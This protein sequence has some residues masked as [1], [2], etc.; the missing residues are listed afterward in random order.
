MKAVVPTQL[1]RT[2]YAPARVPRI[3]QAGISL[4]ET[5]FGV[6]ATIAM[7]AFVFWMKSSLWGPLLGL[8]EASSVST[9]FGKVEAVYSGA[10]N[11]NG[12]TTASMA[13]PSI[14]ASKYLP[15]GGTINN[16][17]GG[18]VSLGIG[19]INTTSDTLQYTEGGVRSDSCTTLVNQLS[20]DA[21]RI[22]V[23]G[24][25]VKALNGTLNAGTLKTQCDS[26][27]TVDIILERIK[28]A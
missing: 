17:F 22:T 7:L 28:R 18:S 21:D 23:A 16:R 25:V 20:D 10:A 27:N 19:T 3:R 13:T 26:A 6:L 4:V 15:G 9:S 11:Y 1:S 24:T 12:L 14:F 8:M 5:L 2:T